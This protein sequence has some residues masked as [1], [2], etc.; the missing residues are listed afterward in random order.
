VPLPLLVALALATALVIIVIG[1]LVLK[2]RKRP[3]V[4]GRESLLGTEGTVLAV[5]GGETWAQVEGERWRVRAR[6]A[7]APGDR[8]RVTAVDGLTLVVGKES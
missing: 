1:G 7:L 2:A 5:D 6:D 4:S 8:V 3:V